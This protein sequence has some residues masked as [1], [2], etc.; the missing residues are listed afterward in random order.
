MYVRPHI[1]Y[2]I[3]SDFNKNLNVLS[4]SR[5]RSALSISTQI[6]L[7]GGAILHTEICKDMLKQTFLQSLCECT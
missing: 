5:K 6:C 4:C 2:L 7:V 3:L 1:K